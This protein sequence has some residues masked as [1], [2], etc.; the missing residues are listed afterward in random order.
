[1]SII[2][3]MSK[4]EDDTFLVT[5]HTPPGTQR[6]VISHKVLTESIQRPPIP[7]R[8]S[9]WLR[10][11]WYLYKSS[12]RKIDIEFARTDR[13]TKGKQNVSGS[14]LVDSTGHRWNKKGQNG[15]VPNHLRSPNFRSW[16]MK[17]SLVNAFAVVRLP[18]IQE[19]HLWQWNTNTPNC[20]C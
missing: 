1:M 2:V 15:D 4:I 12:P 10:L 17:T 9:L 6:L 5:Y 3:I 11:R 14:D 13:K 16:L 19:F 20:P 8:H 18:E 7:C